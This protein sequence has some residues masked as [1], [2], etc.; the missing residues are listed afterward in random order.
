MPDTEPG[1][2]AP[3]EPPTKPGLPLLK[4][5]P[6]RAKQARIASFRRWALMLAAGLAIAGFVLV[7]R[8]MPGPPAVIKPGGSARLPEAAGT[9]PAAREPLPGPARGQRTAVGQSPLQTA[10]QAASAID[11]AVL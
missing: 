10:A 9:G 6:D 1:R 7:L 5:E 8:P 4:F 11:S 3:P 2:P